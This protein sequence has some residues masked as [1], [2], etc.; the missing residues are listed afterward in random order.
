GEASKAAEERFRASEASVAVRQALEITQRELAEATAAV[1]QQLEQSPAYI[2]TRQAHERAQTELENLRAA[3]TVDAATLAAA[4]KRVADSFALLGQLRD[5]ALRDDPAVQAA[6]AAYDQNRATAMALERDFTE[7]K[8]PL[9]EG[10]RAARAAAEEARSAA[11]A[12]EQQLD[13]AQSA[14]RRISGDLQ[15][16]E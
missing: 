6:Q 12:A 11:A 5:R 16:V 7:N 3:P 1:M 8:L 10:Y 13:R 14:R 2:E 9:D 4:E 15:K